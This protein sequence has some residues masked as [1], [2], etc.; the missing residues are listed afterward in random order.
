MEIMEFRLSCNTSGFFKSNK[1]VINGNN[2]IYSADENTEVA[3]IYYFFNIDK[4]MFKF[5]NIKIPI[6]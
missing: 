3:M 4:I 6:Y 1:L 5:L 2:S